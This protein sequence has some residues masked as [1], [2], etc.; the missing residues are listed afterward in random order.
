MKNTGTA[1]QEQKRAHAEAIYDFLRNALDAFG[2][3]PRFRAEVIEECG[4]AFERFL[5][6][7]CIPKKE[8]KP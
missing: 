5:E 7:H 8:A 3:Y 2:D 1:T 4:K 6:K